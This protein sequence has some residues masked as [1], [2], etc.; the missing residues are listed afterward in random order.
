[1]TIT[2][3]RRGG[4]RAGKVRA[5][6]GVCV[7][8]STVVRH[9]IT[10]ALAAVAL[11][12]CG[13]AR[14][15]S[16]YLT[17]LISTSLDAHRGFTV[18]SVTCPPGT[19]SKGAV[20]AGTVV[21]C[22]A[23]L[24]GGHKVGVRATALDGEGTF[25]IVTSEILPDNVEGQ[26]VATLAQRGIKARAVCP[27]HVRVV[28]GRTFECRVTEAGG[29]HLAVAVTIVDADGGFRMAFS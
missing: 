8:I 29:H 15:D 5:G 17:N 10:A 18:A 13:G 22:T 24:R 28:I 14:S 2:V 3:S 7:G 9:L 4:R 26:I 12:S 25:H 27:A 11:A 1:V 16:G 19:G 23:T 20:S 6:A 21:H